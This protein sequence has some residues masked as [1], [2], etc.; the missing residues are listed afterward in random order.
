MMKTTDFPQ[1]T[2]SALI[3][4]GVVLA[5]VAGVIINKI[6][7][8]NLPQPL[9]PGEKLSILDAL[10]GVPYDPNT[11]LTTPQIIRRAGYPAESHTVQTDD[12]YLLELHRIPNELGY[13]IFLQHGLLGCST[14]WIM[15][16]KGRAIAYLLADKGY[17]VWL[18]N[19]RGNT[20]SAAHITLPLDNPKFWNF[21]FHELG[22]YDLPAMITY[23][24]DYKQKP[25]IYIGHS[26]G[27]TGMFVMGSNRLDIH[28][29]VRFVICYAPV[30]LTAHWKGPM[31]AIAP[32]AP[33]FTALGDT[34]GYGPFLTRDAKVNTFT[35]YICD[36]SKL[37]EFEC[38][39]MDFAIFGS[40]YTQFEVNLIPT[41]TSHT[42]AGTST[43]A[44]N[45]Y[46]QMCNSKR[47]GYYDHGP[48]KNLEFYKTPI[49]PDY[50]VS[51]NTLP[52][53]MF[54]G[55]NDKV[56]TG[57]GDEIRDSCPC[58]ELPL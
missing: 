9:T 14:D 31:R 8:G 52:I 58:A 36:A 3:L 42:P 27:T 22:I 12:G 50:N 16:G 44:L 29:R 32:L 17:D 33:A 1:S 55:L 15:Q 19:Y 23:V 38:E 37:E 48:V 40:D 21:S 7:D 10:R 47:F 45:H 39:N 18:G 46:L 2:F 24:T 28:K 57:V 53:F 41:I 49:A 30:G 35:K 43:K 13:P 25:V 11:V 20:Y 34:F 56:A 6:V 54:Y 4:T 5:D 51:K 26:M